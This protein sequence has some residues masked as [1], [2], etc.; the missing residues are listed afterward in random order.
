VV[1]VGMVG[2]AVMADGF[3]APL[4]VV[5]VVVADL[6]LD[7]LTRL[8]KVGAM[9][10]PLQYCAAA[11]LAE[12]LSSESWTPCLDT[13]VPVAMADRGSRGPVKGDEAAAVKRL[14]VV[15]RCAPCAA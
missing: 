7:N 8:A 4:V 5:K 11:A 10:V 14:V 13:V 3:V 9:L 15:A 2:V 6:E 1:V 12:S